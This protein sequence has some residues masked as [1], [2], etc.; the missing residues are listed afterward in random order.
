VEP[1]VGGPEGFENGGLLTAA[2]AMQRFLALLYA[3]QSPQRKT[4]E[5]R[6]RNAE[7]YRRYLEGEDSVVPAG[8]FGLSDRRIR[9]IIERERKRVGR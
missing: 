3:G 8:V 2:E 6:G 1:L 5:K 7:I 9:S 4:W